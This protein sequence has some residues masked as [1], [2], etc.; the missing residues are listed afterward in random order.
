[1]QTVPVEGIGDFEVPESWDESQIQG[2]LKA[3]REKNPHLFPKLTKELTDGPPQRLQDPPATTGPP[4]RETP[5]EA[6][7]QSILSYGMTRQQQGRG[8][9]TAT[10]TSEALAKPLL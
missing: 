4:K 5:P 6:T 8:V 9:A 7:P 10:R 3:F 1:M 2:Y